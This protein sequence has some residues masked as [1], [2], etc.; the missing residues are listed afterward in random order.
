MPAGA[1]ALGAPLAERAGGGFAAGG[2]A[3]DAGGGAAIRGDGAGAS[4][5]TGPGDDAPA[6]GVDGCASLSASGPA[7]SAPTHPASSQARTRRTRIMRKG[8][9]T[10]GSGG[11]RLLARRTGARLSAPPSA[12]PTEQTVTPTYVASHAYVL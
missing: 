3:G 12:R 1:A 10:I 9:T 7:A 2:G 6:C 4:G 5:A 8:T 11:Q